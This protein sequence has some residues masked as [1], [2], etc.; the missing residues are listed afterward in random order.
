MNDGYYVWRG[1]DQEFDVEPIA[2]VL[3]SNN[4][5]IKAGTTA[6]KS[7]GKQQRKSNVEQYSPDR[8]MRRRTERQLHPYEVDKAENPLFGRGNKA[9]A[10]RQMNQLKRKRSTP[11][12]IPRKRGSTST[13]ESRDSTPA[14]ANRPSSR[15]SLSS[16]ALGQN[17]IS[18]T[19]L[20]TWFLE[21]SKN[22]FLPVPLP[23]TSEQLFASIE[24]KWERALAGRTIS[25]CEISFPWLGDSE[26]L[27]LF[28]NDDDSTTVT[29]MRDEIR[30]SPTWKDTNDCRVEIEIV[31][32]DKKTAES[33]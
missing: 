4:S 1:V 28:A 2:T 8:D 18:T 33:A 14:S 5:K 15:T 6:A 32:T 3:R 11:S 21:F 24:R 31:A 17:D 7:T 23:E 20:R 26:K 22:A 25:H 13:R 12:T 16:V 27:L 10:S 29:T 19:K 9:P 30:R